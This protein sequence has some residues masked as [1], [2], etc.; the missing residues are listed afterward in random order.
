MLIRPRLQSR[1]RTAAA[2]LLRPMP[3]FTVIEREQ[4]PGNDSQDSTNAHSDGKF[5]GG[6][7]NEN[8]HRSYSWLAS[9]RRR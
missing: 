9:S 6:Q 8:R 2:A 4:Q 1:D 7:F 5:N 3:Q